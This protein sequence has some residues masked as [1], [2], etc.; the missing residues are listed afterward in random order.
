[1]PAG[2]KGVPVGEALAV[3][4]YDE[5]DVDAFNHLPRY[6]P[7]KAGEEEAAAGGAGEGGE[8]GPADATA[9][10]KCIHKLV[11]AGQIK[12]AGE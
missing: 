10:L 8:V 11:R 6:H 2:T 9:L 4:V 1:M 3:L 7:A 12:D 5:K